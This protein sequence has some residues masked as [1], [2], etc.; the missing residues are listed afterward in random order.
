MPASQDARIAGYVEEAGQGIIIVANKCDLIKG[1]TQGRAH[2]EQRT[3]SE[4]AFISYVPILFVSALNNKGI[5]TLME[6]AEKVASNHR[7]RIG[8]SVLNEVL[9]EAQFR[10]APPQDKGR[11][12]KIYYGAQVSTSPPSFA[13]FMNYPNLMTFSYRRYLENTLRESFDFQGVPLR[14]LLR[15]RG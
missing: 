5:S 3:R 11:Q 6:V 8:T 12:L 7:R 9:K 2:F 15:K 14:F 4:M 13:L 1:G 10:V